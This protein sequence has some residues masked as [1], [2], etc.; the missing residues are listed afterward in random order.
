MSAVVVPADTLVA[1]LKSKGF[2]ERDMA[3]VRGS[4]IVY[5]RSHKADTRYKVLIYTSVRRGSTVARAAGKDAIRVCAIFE[6][7]S[8][9][10]GVCKLP[11]VH[12]TGTVE[13]VLERV[14]GRAREAYEACSK[15]RH[16]R[17]GSLPR[18]PDG[19]INNCA[20]KHD[21]P[22]STCQMCRGTCPDV[23]DHLDA[24]QQKHHPGS[25]PNGV[26]RSFGD[27]YP[28]DDLDGDD[29]R[30]DLR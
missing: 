20:R 28:E 18:L 6:D 27:F 17:S 25:R 2:A 13:G 8:Y 16:S 10:R 12:R 11:R 3:K 7:G 4:E 1:F 19:T 29:E 23:R 15:T 26:E 22:M 21:Q 14:L 5:E 24:V 9:S 30:G